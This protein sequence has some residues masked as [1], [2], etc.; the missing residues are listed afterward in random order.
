MEAP[1]TRMMPLVQSAARALH[2]HFDKPFAFFGHSMGAIISFELA[3]HLR[4]EG[5]AGPVS[6]L[7]SG[8]RAPQVPDTDPKTYDLPEEELLEELRRLKGTPKQV[9]EHP[10]LVKM[11]LPL[12]RGDFELCQTYEY[13]E[14]SPLRCP[15]FALGGLQDTEEN[16]DRIERWKEQTSGDF[17]LKIIAGGHFFLH[18][19]ESQLL[20]ILSEELR[21]LTQTWPA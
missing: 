11:M 15:I 20:C 12:I 5:R 6:L 21:H 4:R 7:V 1:F 13:T 10:E 2:P 19:C 14:E 17:S 3:R 9:L 18:S 16:L 8:R